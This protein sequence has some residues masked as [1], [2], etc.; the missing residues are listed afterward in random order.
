MSTDPSTT[1]ALSFE[2]VQDDDLAALG[3]SQPEGGGELRQQRATNGGQ[4]RLGRRTGGAD[5]SP[6]G[7]CA[8]AG[9]AA[10]SRRQSAPSGRGGAARP[11]TAPRSGRGRAPLS[12]AG[13]PARRPSGP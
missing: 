11:R 9:G 5:F 13:A 4:G 6:A 2:P 12:F 10:R 7:D 1:S 3:T 8:V